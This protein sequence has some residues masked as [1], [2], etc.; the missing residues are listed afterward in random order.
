MGLVPG[1]TGLDAHVD[2]NNKSRNHIWSASCFFSSLTSLCPSCGQSDASPPDTT[3]VSFRL[4][5]HT[6]LPYTS[7]SVKYTYIYIYAYYLLLRTR[8]YVYAYIGTYS[9]LCTN[10]RMRCCVDC[11]APCDC[12]TLQT[13]PF[14][15]PF[16]RRC[17]DPGVSSHVCLTIFAVPLQVSLLYHRVRSV[18][19]PL[20]L[21]SQ[22]CLVYY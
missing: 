18:A 3:H 16:V 12:A 22:E 15:V 13:Q 20:A 10:I 21:L 8:T 5:E 7:L 6:L 4:H 2:C 17:T 14:R 1:S 19:A 11:R 9:L